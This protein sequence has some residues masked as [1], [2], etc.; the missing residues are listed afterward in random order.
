MRLALK[1]VQLL[2]IIIVEMRPTMPA[3]VGHCSLRNQRFI[4]LFAW[5]QL[6]MGCI[7]AI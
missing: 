7:K 2:P 5:A 1:Q 3:A 4:A 6:V